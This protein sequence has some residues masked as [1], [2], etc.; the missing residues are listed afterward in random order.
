MS[1]SYKEYASKEYVH[2]VVVSKENIEQIVAGFL[3]EAKA[4]AS[5]VNEEHNIATDSHN[6]IRELITG[7]TTRLNTLADSDDTTLDQLSEIIAFIKSNKDLIDAI[8]TDRIRVTDIVNDLTTNDATKPLSAAQGVVIKE[9]FDGIRHLPEVTTDDNDK[10]LVVEEGVWVAKKVESGASSWN[11]LTDKPFG[12][13]LVE[14]IEWDG[15][16]EGRAQGTVPGLSGALFNI[17]DVV[18]TDAADLVGSVVTIVDNNTGELDSEY[19]LTANDVRGQMGMLMV[20]SFGS[21]PSFP[22]AMIIAPQDDFNIE[23]SPGVSLNLPKKGFYTARANSAGEDLDFRLSK[24]TFANPIGE[25]KKI[26]EKYLPDTVATKSDIQ[27]YIDN[28]ILN[29]AW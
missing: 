15:S 25:I 7:L 2:S 20:T 23:L 1:N 6:D 26:D 12:E 19:T 29:G 9:L 3:A 10:A 14:F 28:A 24:L 5:Q 8:T 13:D 4:Y 17:S 21:D 27:T 16:T 11:D 18:I 22:V